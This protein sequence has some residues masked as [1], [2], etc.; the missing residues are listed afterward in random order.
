MSVMTTMRISSRSDDR[1]LTVIRWSAASFAVVTYAAISTR[2]SLSP[3]EVNYFFDAKRMFSVAIGT[4]VLWLSICA[5]DRVS[6]DNRGAHIYAILNV[7]IPGAIALLIAREAYD[8]LESGEFAQKSALNLRWMLTWIGYFAAAVA[9]FLAFTAHRRLQIAHAQ[10][11]SGSG[12]IG[13]HEK[14]SV[15]QNSYELADMDFDINL[16]LTPGPDRPYPPFR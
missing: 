16:R 5:S 11:P 3:Y 9:G 1:A 4:F 10:S 6:G 14:P 7:A 8:L 13:D 2:A 12:S 15:D